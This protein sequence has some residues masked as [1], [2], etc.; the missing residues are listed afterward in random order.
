[1]TL[2]VC[3]QILPPRR[4]VFGQL[5]SA[6]LLLRRIRNAS[7]KRR[8]ESGSLFRRRSSEERWRYSYDLKSWFAIIGNIIKILGNKIEIAID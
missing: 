8:K 4:I 1:M 7:L 2:V 5:G 3:V 6:S